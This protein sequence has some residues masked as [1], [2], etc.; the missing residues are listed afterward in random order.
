MAIHLLDSTRGSA[1][2]PTC[3]GVDDDVA[4]DEAFD[5]VPEHTTCAK[6]RAEREAALV[7]LRTCPLC[8]LTYA[9]EQVAN[10]CK[11]KHGIIPVSHRGEPL[12]FALD[13]RDGYDNPSYKARALSLAYAELRRWRPNDNFEVVPSRMMID[14]EHDGSF[15]E[16]HVVGY[17]IVQK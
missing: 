8:A 5:R 15:S 17:L 16:A 11:M 9:N 7:Y 1:A 14:R 13:L 3:S 6:C 12:A 10:D 4:L 2:R